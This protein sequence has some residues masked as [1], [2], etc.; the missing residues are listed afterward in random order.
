LTGSFDGINAT[1]SRQYSRPHALAGI[2]LIR[3]SI[4][5]VEPFL[6]HLYAALAEKERGLIS[7]RTKAA[8]AAATARG[9]S[10]GNPR[11]AD[12]RAIAHAASR[13]GADDMGRH[14]RDR[15]AE[16]LLAALMA[17]APPCPR[18]CSPASYSRGSGCRGQDASRDRGRAERARHRH[19]SR[20]EMG[21]D[22]GAQR[23]SPS[24][25][26]GRPGAQRRE[27]VELDQLRPSAHFR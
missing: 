1:P 15:D 11:L 14:P 2:G 12:A 21:G 16:S 27:P 5:L 24:R 17:Y 8:L 6:L 7:Q 4:F 22:D 3:T 25:M 10:L 19:G 23:P 13:A 9:P 18:R 20:W 26:R